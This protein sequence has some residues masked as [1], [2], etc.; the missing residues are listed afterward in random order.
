MGTLRIKIFAVAFT[1]LLIWPAMASAEDTEKSLTSWGLGIRAFTLMGDKP[2]VTEIVVDP[3]VVCAEI[4]VR[5]WVVEHFI[6]VHGAFAYGIAS[7]SL[8]AFGGGFRI[9]IF[10]SLNPATFY[11]VPQMA[12]KFAGS[13]AAEEVIEDPHDRPPR[14]IAL[15]PHYGL[16]GN[17]IQHFLIV[18]GVGAYYMIFPSDQPAEYFG[19]TKVFAPN[20][21]IGAIFKFGS[22]K[23]QP[24]WFALDLEAAFF[25]MYGK[26]FLSPYFGL[27]FKL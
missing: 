9:N 2:P 12:K 10:E 1:T 21:S 27:S 15:N 26:W 23:M 20:I 5:H 19:E 13:D 11:S 3:N 24:A 22:S 18:F 17:T 4:N 7:G 6:E 16:L 8:T 25:Q 14:I